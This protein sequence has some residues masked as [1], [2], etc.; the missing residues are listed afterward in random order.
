MRLEVVDGFYFSV[1]G[2]HTADLAL[3]NLGGADRH[4][5]IAAGDEGS[6]DND[7]GE[8]DKRRGPPTPQW[9]FRTVSIQWHAEKSASFNVSS[10]RRRKARKCIT[11]GLPD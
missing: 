6:Q 2:N 8:D 3:F 1:G 7:P 9:A 4:G 10:M 5:N 11:L